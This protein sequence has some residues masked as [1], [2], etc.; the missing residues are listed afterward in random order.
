MKRK[1]NGKVYYQLLSIYH[2]ENQ[3]VDECNVKLLAF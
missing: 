1:K 2:Y 3:E